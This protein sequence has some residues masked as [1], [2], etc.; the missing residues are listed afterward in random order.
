MIRKSVYAASA[1]CLPRS[2]NLF[3][4]SSLSTGFAWYKLKN[5]SLKGGDSSEAFGT[6]AAVSR[7]SLVINR[8]VNRWHAGLINTLPWPAP[9]GAGLRQAMRS[10]RPPGRLTSLPIRRSA[11]LPI[12][13]FSNRSRHS[14]RLKL[15]QQAIKEINCTV[16][17][18]VWLS[19]SKF[20]I[21]I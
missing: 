3:K 5:S 17:G 21:I 2:I 10:R 6:E 16:F 9:E 7:F 11:A 20:D 4:L 12:F 15:Y 8:H 1:L 14:Y 18:F 19:F 13:R